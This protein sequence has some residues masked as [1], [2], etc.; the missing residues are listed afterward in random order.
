MNESISMSSL[1][2]LFSLV[3][4]GPD[5]VHNCYGAL[6]AFDRYHIT[7]LNNSGTKLNMLAIYTV[8]Q[9]KMASI[10]SSKLP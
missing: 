9:K 7:Q 10:V 1:A 5:V 8:S 4:L 3:R 6:P 2:S